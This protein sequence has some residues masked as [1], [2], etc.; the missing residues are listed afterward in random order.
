MNLLV[1]TII[2][3]FAGTVIS[4]PVNKSVVVENTLMNDVSFASNGG[5]DNY[6]Q[7]IP[8]QYTEQCGNGK[9]DRFYT[10]K[11]PNSTFF[12]FCEKNYVSR[13]GIC[14]YKRA[15][16][17][18]VFAASLLGGYLG[19]DWFTLARG[20]SVYIG[21]GFAKLGL[22]LLCIFLFMCNKNGGV[23]NIIIWL[24]GIVVLWWLV[25]WIRAATKDGFPDG[26]GYSMGAFSDDCTA[27]YYL[28]SY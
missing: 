2:L 14:N 1:P 21:I 23:H 5:F 11:Y 15:N 13:N 24:V 27:I 22:T 12:C 6:A 4:A 9:C 18:A 16:H 20:N 17:D 10:E 8:C 25:D 3:W 26:N 19:A 28:S 7:L